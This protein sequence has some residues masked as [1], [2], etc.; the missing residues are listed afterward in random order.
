MW[1]T[2]PEPVGPKPPT[3]KVTAAGDWRSSEPRK[4]MCQILALTI[5]LTACQPPGDLMSAFGLKPASPPSSR[6]YPLH[7]RIIATTFWVGE[8]V[9]PGA[10]DGSQ[11]RS[12]YDS[13]WMK[14]YGGCDGVW[15]DGHCMTEARGPDNGYFPRHMTPRENPF[16]LDLPFSDVHDPIAFAQRGAVVPWAHDHNYSGRSKD[17]DF[18]YMKNRWVKLVTNA[19]ICYG[20]IQDAGPSEY[21]D[22]QYVFGSD[23]L[24]PRSARFNGAGLDV[25]PALNGCLGFSELNGAND[26]V[27]WQFVDDVDVPPGPWKIIVTTRPFTR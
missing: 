9:D 8:V 24:R 23:D 5:T 11:I 1:T 26:K 14:N 27:S 20:Q 15:I 2:L 17:P 13:Q 3:A 22:A 6:T 7:T 12:A 18:S 21:H 4:L 25:S 16:Y 19:A 10:A